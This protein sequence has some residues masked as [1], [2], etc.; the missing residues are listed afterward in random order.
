VRYCLWRDR[1]A[2]VTNALQLLAYA[3]VAYVA[4][5]PLLAHGSHPA[6]LDALAGT[7]TLLGWLFAINLG[8]AAWR[9]GMKA[10]FVACLY[11]PWQALLS[12]PRLVLGNFIGIFAT[13]RAVAQFA[14]H[15]VT[16]KPLRWL[17]TAH[18]FPTKPEEVSCPPVTR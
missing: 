5:R 11:G 17:K 7:G 8:V 18:T 14:R 16:G 1:K 15:R 6:A 9:A 4:A 12:V 2:L 10:R 13:A 3:L